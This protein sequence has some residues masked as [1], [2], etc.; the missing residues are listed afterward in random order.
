MPEPTSRDP[1]SSSVGDYLKAIW[2]LGGTEAVST[3]DLAERLS[4]AAPSVSEMLA[5]L[6]EMGLVQH[7]P[8]RGARLAPA[9]RQEALRLVR[10]HRLIET[11]LVEHLGYAWDEVHEEAEVLEHAVSDRFVECLDALLRHPSHDP[12][13][14]P[15]P[16]P[17]GTFPETPAVPL[18]RA[19]VGALF[20]VS[21]LHTQDSRDLG[22]LAALGIVPGRT[23]RIEEE[24]ET[25]VLTVRLEGELR[26]LPRR[27]A[28]SVQGEVV[29]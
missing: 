4:I 20:R 1:L 19:E 18:T 16:R 27:L 7:E 15:I 25:S 6:H 13:G 24:G 17:D 28:E 29:G 9:G 23:L 5:R 3:K 10:R 11:Y 12:H 21:R 2:S 14:D 22:E 8:Y 26:V